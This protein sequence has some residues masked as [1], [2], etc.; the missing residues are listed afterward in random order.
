MF[1]LHD[2]MV[3]DHL[4]HVLI[5]EEIGESEDEA[6]INQ[7]PLPWDE[8]EPKMLRAVEEWNQEQVRSA[9]PLLRSCLLV[10]QL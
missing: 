6:S 8:P 1:L 9:R 3:D 2:S 4:E 10:L 7:E 5:K